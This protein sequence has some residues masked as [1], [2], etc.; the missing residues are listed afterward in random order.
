VRVALTFDRKRDDSE[1]EAE[2][3]TLETVG[4]LTEILLGLGHDVA[5][6]EVS[7]PIPL[8]VER[9][10]RAAPRVVFN[11]AEGRVGRFREAFYPA[12]FEQL[13]LRHTGSPAS[14]LALCLDKAL[15]KRVVAAAGVPVAAG[16]VVRG[17]GGS[18]LAGPR[19]PVI[20]KPNYEGSSKG[21]T[22]ASVASDAR[23]LRAVVREQLR[24]YPDGVLVEEYV[25]GV[26]VGVAF[27]D[28]I[29]ILPPLCWRYEATGPH[30]ILDLVLKQGPPERVRV[31]V[32][33]AIGGAASAR[34]VEAARRAF[35]ALDVAGFGRAD[36]RVTPD[37]DVRFLEMNPLPTLAP[38]EEEMYAAA[39]HV[40][41]SRADVLDAII[42]ASRRT[43]RV[44]HPRV[45]R[46]LLCTGPPSCSA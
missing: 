7:C 14:V 43:G 16:V 38:S 36:F 4:A 27:V 31:E 3:D 5:A 13:R 37:G 6:V 15:A 42:A 40:G 21:I 35:A 41:R 23:G 45:G 33:A 25:D 8:L 1:E 19:L 26:D 28:G 46:G 22:Q 2:F 10:Q 34:V 20:V 30:Q 24:R 11:I 29:G 12:L 17:R 32:P 39:A 9:L 18:A 44:R